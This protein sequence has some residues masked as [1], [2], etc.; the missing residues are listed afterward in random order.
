MAS[1]SLFDDEEEDDRQDDRESQRTKQPF[2]DDYYGILGLDKNATADDIRSAYR[3]RSR[4][5]HPDKH[6]SLD[7]GKQQEAVLIF[8]RVKRA[9]DILSDEHLRAVYDT[10]G[11]DGLDALGSD[12]FD[13]DSDQTSK[14]QLILRS[15]TPKEI[16]EE[17]EE[18]QK[19]KQRRRLEQRSNPKGTLIVGINAS[20]IF[21]FLGMGD[22]DEDDDEEEELLALP[23][24]EVSSLSVVQ[25]IDVPLSLKETSTLSGQLV[26]TNGRG[27]G[28]FGTSYRRIVSDRSWVE[29]Q[30]LIGRGPVAVV[31]GFRSIG[32][33][34]HC[35]AVL[36]LPVV[37]QGNTAAIIPSLDIGLGRS[38]TKT[39]SAEVKGSL[40]PRSSISSHLVYV[41]RGRHQVVCSVQ[42][43]LKESF[44]GLFYHHRLE[45]ND[46]KVKIGSKV[47][48]K[49]VSL[50]YGVETKSS[51]NSIVGATVILGVPSGVSLKLR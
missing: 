15:K 36:S 12:L 43:G 44:F 23:S 45:W 40:G 35:T 18:I 10:L 20:E 3:S 50:E 39:C 9:H 34:S 48:T 17:F 19:E 41:L 28:H 31:K 38:F 1:Y 37:I 46:T 8:N 6:S 49:G 51:A 11:Q 14:T 32:E 16:R 7:P 21:E 4:M 27:S 29:L 26:T 42:A 13:N 22:Y 47:G 25:S 24:V 5:F 30:F 33:K 2:Q